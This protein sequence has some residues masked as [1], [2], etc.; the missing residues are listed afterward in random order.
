MCLAPWHPL[1]WSLKSSMVGIHRGSRTRVISYGHFAVAAVFR[2]RESHDPLR[3]HWESTVLLM[4]TVSWS[5]KF[6]GLALKI[7]AFLLAAGR[8]TSCG[9]EKLQSN[10]AF[11]WRRH[12]SWGWYPNGW[13]IVGKPIEIGWFRGFPILGNLHM[14]LWYHMYFICCFLFLWP[15]SAHNQCC[16][17]LFLCVIPFK[18]AKKQCWCKWGRTTPAKRSRNMARTTRNYGFMMIYESFCCWLVLGCSSSQSNDS[19][20]TCGPVAVWSFDN[21]CFFMIFQ[22]GEVPSWPSGSGYV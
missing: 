22:P 15:I 3:I 11:P 1:G 4:K 16:F 7:P 19:P 5:G 17:M 14:T 2:W 12:W 18:W 8:K 21:S 20:G 10:W 6:Q 13:F 9:P